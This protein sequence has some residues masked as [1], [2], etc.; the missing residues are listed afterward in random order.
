MHIPAQFLLC[1]MNILVCIYI[2]LPD[3]EHIPGPTSLYECP[4]PVLALCHEHT[5]T[6][7]MVIGVHAY[8]C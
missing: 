8:P 7:S 5:N 6:S 1:A 2:S 4:C 3:I